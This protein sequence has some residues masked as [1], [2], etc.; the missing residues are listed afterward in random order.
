MD[1]CVESNGEWTVDKLTAIAL[2]SI[3]GENNYDIYVATYTFHFRRS[4]AFYII[5]IIIPSFVLT[6]LCVLG[7][8]WSRFDQTDYLEKLGLGFA[9]ILAMCTILEI[10]EESVPKT[11]QLPLLSIYIMINLLL[12]TVAISIVVIASKTCSLSFNSVL[13]KRWLRRF[14]LNLCARFRI[15]CLVLFPLAVIANLLALVTNV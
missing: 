1:L 4:S 5:L 6:F 12:L 11:R 13:S 8:F 15:I 2:P 7:L 9:A 3:E 10:A 14:D